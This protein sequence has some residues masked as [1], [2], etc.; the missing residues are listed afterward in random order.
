MNIRR[1]SE[2]DLG[3]LLRLY[4]QLSPGNTSTTREQ[5]APALL[6]LLALPGATLLVS[7]QDGVVVGTVTLVIVP[8][9]THN[10]CPWAQVENMVVD[11]SLRGSGAGRQL[12]AECVRLAHEANCYK[13]QL[14]S[15][16]QRRSRENDA[17]GFY[18]HLGFAASSAGFRLYLD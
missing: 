8:N 9:L 5:A 13:V 11:E 4:E 15:G 18:E 14:Q 3:A 17:H 7:E 10:A 16:N 12:I 6:A 1:A 2:G